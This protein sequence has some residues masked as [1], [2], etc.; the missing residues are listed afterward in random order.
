MFRPLNIVLIIFLI[1]LGILIY[2]LFLNKEKNPQDIAISTNSS[3]GIIMIDGFKLG[4]REVCLPDVKLG[5][6]V[7]SL[8]EDEQIKVEQTIKVSDTV[9]KL[10][11]EKIT[12]Q[13]V[14]LQVQIADCKNWKSD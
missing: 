5:Q 8:L 9:V 10:L 7:V 1:I 6:H 3:T 11:E 13:K 12:D 4:Q 14:N 2:A